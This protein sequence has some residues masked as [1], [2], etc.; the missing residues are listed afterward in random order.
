MKIVPTGFRVL[1]E[2]DRLEKTSTGGIILAREG[3]D[4]RHQAGQETATVVALGPTAFKGFDDGEPWCKVGDRVRIVRYSGNTIEDEKNEK[5]YSII[6]DED[7][8]AVIE[9]EE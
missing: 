9:D 4:R 1:V 6:N 3:G 7:V 5:M 8:Y 2:L